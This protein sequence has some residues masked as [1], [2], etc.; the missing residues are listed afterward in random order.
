MRK[1]RVRGEKREIESEREIEIQ[2]KNARKKNKY[3]KK[4]LFLYQQK[5]RKKGKNNE[6]L[7]VE[8]VKT[9]MKM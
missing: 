3:R 6:R 5:R 4:N 8:K 7:G 2:R 9:Q 1:E